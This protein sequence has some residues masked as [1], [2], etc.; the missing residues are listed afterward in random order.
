[1]GVQRD[2][3]D[4]GL[5]VTV[6]SPTTVKG[7][8]SCG[9]VAHGHG[10]VAVRLIDTPSAGRPVRIRLASSVGG[11]ARSPR[12]PVGTFV[13]QDE[14]IAAPRA[15]LTAR[16]CRWAIEQTTPRARLGQRDPP[17]AGLRVAHRVGGDR[18]AAAGRRR[19]PESRF[20]GVTHLGVDE[21]VWHHVSTKPIEARRTRPEGAD[22]DGRPDPGC[23]RTRHNSTAGPGPGTLRQGLQGLARC[24]GQSFR[25]GVTVA[26]LDPFHGYKNAIDDELE[27]ARAVLDAFHVVK[28]AT[29][30]STTSAAAYSRTSTGHRGRKATRCTGSATSCAPDTRT[31]PSGNKPDLTPRGPLDERARRGRTR[32]PMRPTGPRRLSP[33]HPDRWPSRWPRQSST[34]C[35]AAPSPRSPAWAEP[36]NNGASEFLGYFDTNRASNG[37]TEAINGLIELHRRIARGFR[38]RDNY[39]LRMLLI[40]G[41]LDKSPHTQR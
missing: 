39:R 7:C 30:S 36:S 4:G 25:S 33:D 13:E 19:R 16:A 24:A 15:S 31:S 40:A 28:F 2:D 29:R 32:L 18:T 34:A 6:E 21:H 26:T 35:Q 23:Q 37:G 5:T 1:M 22:R 8:P 38:N 41:G 11:C 20:V 3:R 14:R 17:P 10:R 12:C 9:V 27:D